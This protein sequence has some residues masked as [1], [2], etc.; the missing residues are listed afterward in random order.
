MTCGVL[1]YFGY[2]TTGDADPVRWRA[3]GVPPPRHLYAGGEVRGV[4][5]AGGA[6]PPR[7]RSWMPAGR[8]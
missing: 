7:T 5:T 3:G 2:P 6:W 1:R 8:V 4:E